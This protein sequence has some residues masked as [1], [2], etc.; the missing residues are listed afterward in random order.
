[1]WHK[2]GPSSLSI[3]YCPSP[4]F[5][6][7]ILILFIPRPTLKKVKCWQTWFLSQN[8]EAMAHGEVPKYLIPSEDFFSEVFTAHDSFYFDEYCIIEYDFVIET[9]QSCL[10]LLW[11][12]AVKTVEICYK[13]CFCPM[14]H[15][16]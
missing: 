9:T 5:R 16:K 7:H 14:F 2:K 10:I 6:T 12:K 8:D 4:I 11:Y 13:S 15:F 3:I 1:M